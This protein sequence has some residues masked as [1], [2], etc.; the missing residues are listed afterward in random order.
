MSSDERS[1]DAREEQAW[2]IPDMSV[3]LDVSR[4]ERSRDAREEQP[5][6]M[7]CMFATSEV[8]RPDRSIDTTFEHLRN[9]PRVV[10]A[11]TPF[12]IFTDVISPA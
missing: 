7:L 5:E 1:R 2:N 3:T 8:S 6:N 11:I 4:E 9:I 10:L 12:S